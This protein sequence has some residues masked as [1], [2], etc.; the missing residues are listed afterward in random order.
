MIEFWES[1]S[2]LNWHLHKV[3]DRE[4]KSSNPMPVYLCKMS[5]DF[6]RKSECDDILCIWK[7]TFQA[8]DGKRNHF[9]DLLNVNFNVIKPSYA[10]GGPWLH[11]IT[12]NP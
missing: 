11:V 12:Q 9:L 4:L 10:K 2:H 1:P 5:W 6:S 8:L 7:M 3:V